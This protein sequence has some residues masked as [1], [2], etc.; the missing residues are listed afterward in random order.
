MLTCFIAS[1]KLMYL[2]I[3]HLYFISAY[4]FSEA[5]LTAIADFITEVVSVE[6]KRAGQ[7]FKV[8]LSRLFLFLFVLKKNKKGKIESAAVAH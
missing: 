5:A 8:S 4:K 6:H 3:P 2:S 7:S 1:P